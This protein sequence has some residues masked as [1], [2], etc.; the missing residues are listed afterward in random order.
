MNNPLLNEYRN[1]LRTADEAVKCVKS[2]DYVYYSHFASQPVCLD[3]A[4]AK[5]AGA[6]TNVKI[7][8]SHATRMAEV[9]I[10]DPE[11]NSFQYTTT[12]VSKLERDLYKRGICSYIPS[13]FSEHPFRLRYG[14]Y[15][16]PDVVMCLTTPMD[17]AGLFNFGMHN[18]YISAAMEMGKKIIVEVNTNV[19][20][21]LGGQG[22]NI[23]ISKVDYIVESDNYPLVTVTSPEATEKEKKMAGFI[24]EEIKDGACLQLGI[25]GIPGM[26]G[27]ALLESDL[28]DLGVHSEM[29]NDSFMR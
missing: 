25:G 15:D 5:R 4:L 11:R 12:F 13:N 29:M 24:F 2:G 23:H 9:I 21:C 28:K 14:Y 16:T 17:K 26:I 6:L 1:K 27:S 19:P 8:V 7:L 3:K 22:E 18:S 10:A 20:R